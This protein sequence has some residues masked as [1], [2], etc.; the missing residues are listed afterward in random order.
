MSHASVTAL[1]LAAFMLT[2][3]SSNPDIQ[4]FHLIV[5]S[6]LDRITQ[7]C[8]EEDDPAKFRDG[9][10]DVLVTFNTRPIKH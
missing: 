10:I 6:I 1:T 3:D 9:V 4:I 8:S 5:D 7:L 2:R